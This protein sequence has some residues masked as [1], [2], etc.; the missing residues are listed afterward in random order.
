M[1]ADNSWPTVT[2][3]IRLFKQFIDFGMPTRHAKVQVKRYL[4]VKPRHFTK[5]IP[6]IDVDASEVWVLQNARI[7]VQIS[8]RLES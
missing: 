8:H 2:F 4:P 1:S 7:K 3:D 6:R 5:K